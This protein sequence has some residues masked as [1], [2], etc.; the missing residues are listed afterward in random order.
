[1]KPMDMSHTV[2]AGV[3]LLVGCFFLYHAR[4][5]EPLPWF[6]WSWWLPRDSALAERF[7]RGM[8]WY[9][10]C[11]SIVV[12]IIIVLKGLGWLR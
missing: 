1:M 4:R 10:G 5:R 9:G 3:T 12:S 2:G 11:L 7:G 8:A 6:L